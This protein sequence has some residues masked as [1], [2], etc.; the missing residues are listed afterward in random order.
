MVEK[1]SKK[2]WESFISQFFFLTGVPNEEGLQYLRIAASTH[3]FLTL[4]TTILFKE[5]KTFK[6]Q[7]VIM[8]ILLTDR[9]Y[10]SR[11]IC[12]IQNF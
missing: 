4:M 7:I 12:L 2:S 6:F 11:Q 3:Y 8:I 1:P 10:F 9:K 5:L